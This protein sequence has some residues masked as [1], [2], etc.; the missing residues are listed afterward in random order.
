RDRRRPDPD[1]ARHRN[2]RHGPGGDC[3]DHHRRPVA[4]PLPD[5]AARAGG[6][7]EVR[8][9]REGARR[10]CREGLARAH[11]R[12]D[13]PGAAPCAGQA[14]KARLSVVIAVL[15]VW[16]A[17]ARQSKPFALDSA[18][19][20]RLVNVAVEPDVLDGKKGVRV[21]SSPEALR[22]LQAMTPEQQ[23]T[24][25]SLAI[26]DGLD[27]GNGTIETEIAGM[28]APDAPEGAR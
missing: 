3:R 28:P 23:A 12:R 2:R 26:V 9:A 14:M 27:F 7:C 8:R 10:R 11:L 24:M 16:P 19:G 25:E 4:V 1:L 17:S 6:L 22:R 20:L 5:A 18:T 13:D 21:A 15:L